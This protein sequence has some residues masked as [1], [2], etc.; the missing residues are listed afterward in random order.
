MGN[1][2]VPNHFTIW[3]SLQ[4]TADLLHGGGF[5]LKIIFPV[6]A[7]TAP[8]FPGPGGIEGAFMWRPEITNYSVLQKCQPPLVIQES[9]SP[10]SRPHSSLLMSLIA[11]AKELVDMIKGLRQ[12]YYSCYMIQYLLKFCNTCY[13]LVLWIHL[14]VLTRIKVKNKLSV[15]TF[16]C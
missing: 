6:R 11:E 12:W 14:E 7:G 8:G 15:I 9:R 4:Q 1:Q 16:T 5:L 10:H 13:G 2:V 3:L